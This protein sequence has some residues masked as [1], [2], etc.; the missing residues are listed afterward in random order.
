MSPGWW[1]TMVALCS[2]VLFG[3]LYFGVF[4]LWVHRY[5]GAKGLKDELNKRLGKESDN[6]NHS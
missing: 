3:V 6:G 1:W 5:G 4:L 2:L